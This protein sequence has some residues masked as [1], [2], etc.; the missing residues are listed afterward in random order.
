M[1][2]D[3]W[4]RHRETHVGEQAAIAPFNDCR[5]GRVIRAYRS[6]AYRIKAQGFGELSELVHIHMANV[7]ALQCLTLHAVRLHEEGGPDVLV[8]E[9]VPDA[10]ANVG[11]TLIELRAARLLG[12]R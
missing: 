5:L 7:P 2:R 1:T 12:H 10:Q 9:D 6:G 4:P 11:E 3:L 8:H